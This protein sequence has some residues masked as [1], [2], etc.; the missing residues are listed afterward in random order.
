MHKIFADFFQNEKI[1]VYGEISAENLH[2]IQPHLMPD[3]IKSAIVWLIPY[4][5]GHHPDRNISLYAVSKDYHLYSKELGLRLCRA[6]KEVFPNDEFYSFCDS[7][8]VNEVAAAVTAGLGVLG[9]NRLLINETYGSFV[10]VSC[11][12]STLEPDA[13]KNEP[14]KSCIGCG[15]CLSACD[16]L[17]G[18]SDVCKSELNQRKELTESELK[19]VRSEKIRWGCDVCQQVCPMNKDVPLTPISFF[20]E[21][22]IEKV[23]PQLLS[24]MPKSEFKQRAF[25]WRGKKTI[26]RNVS[27]NCEEN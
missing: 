5:T 22:L 11:L 15:R 3:G 21:D 2:I 1:T 24:E 26:L 18:K 25:A 8:P 6:A 14:L 17:S 9:K 10:F 13:P 27:E 7:S 20:Y 12:L 4:Y 16:F 19:A 23:T